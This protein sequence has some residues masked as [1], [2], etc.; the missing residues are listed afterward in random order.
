VGRRKIYI[1]MS[2]I[3]QAAGGVLSDRTSSST[4]K[5]TKT[6]IPVITI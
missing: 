1:P 4:K 6:L 3:F 2:G 5:A